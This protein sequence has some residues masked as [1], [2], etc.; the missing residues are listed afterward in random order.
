MNTAAPGTKANSE[1][2]DNKASTTKGTTWLAKGAREVSV[3]F[4]LGHERVYSYP[5]SPCHLLLNL[6]DPTLYVS[7]R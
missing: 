2:R 3:R 4:K 5:R 7:L 1:K 6:R